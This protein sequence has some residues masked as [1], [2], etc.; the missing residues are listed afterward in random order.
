MKKP[1]TFLLLMTVHYAANS[2]SFYTKVSAGYA[3][4]L[5]AEMIGYNYTGIF[6]EEIDPVNGNVVVGSIQ[7]EESLEGSFSTGFS[8]SAAVGYRFTDIVGLEINGSYFLG[9]EYKSSQLFQYILDDELTREYRT[10]YARS[11]R[12]FTVSPALRTDIPAG[13][14]RLKPFLTVGPSVGWF[15]GTYEYNDIS[16]IGGELS[17]QKAKEKYSGG[18]AL[19]IRSSLGIELKVNET[20][21]FF[22]EMAVSAMRYHPKEKEITKYEV[23]NEDR[24]STLTEG[25]RKTSLVNKVESDSRTED[26]VGEEIGPS[27]GMNNIAAM[28]GI[29]ISF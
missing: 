10:T 9:S 22:A 28:G 8:A 19:G 23:D 29:K 25:Q 18:V 13:D 11:V 27:F 26:Y 21:S 17:S 14:G 16:N 5:A 3:F 2:Q 4:P 20:I 7:K 12:G 6:M 15:T 24:L 1:F